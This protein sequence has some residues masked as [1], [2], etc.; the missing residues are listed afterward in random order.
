MIQ[1]STLI[2][3]KEALHPYMYIIPSLIVF[4][5]FVLTPIVF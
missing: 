5:L 2:K 4:L 1:E 3:R